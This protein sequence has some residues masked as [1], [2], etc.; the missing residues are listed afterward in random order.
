MC[1]NVSIIGELNMN[2]NLGCLLFIQE[3]Q[4]GLRCARGEFLPFQMNLMLQG[5]GFQTTTPLDSPWPV[6][7]VI[8]ASKDFGLI[9]VPEVSYHRITD[10]DKF[11]VLATDGVWDVLSNDEVVSIVGAASPSSAAQTLSAHRAWRTKYPTSK[12]DDCAAVCLFL[13]SS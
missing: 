9:S 1:L 5:F 3:K 13:S 12:T 8:S 11:V 7:L 6:L 4:R 10:K 2:I